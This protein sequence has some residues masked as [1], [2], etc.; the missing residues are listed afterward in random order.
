MVMYA[1]NWNASA[2]IFGTSS[3]F[4]FSNEFVSSTTDRKQ[5]SPHRNELQPSYNLVDGTEPIPCAVN[6]ERRGLEARKVSCPQFIRSFR[7]VE[8]V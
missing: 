6:E 7:R 8:R 5:F 1:N 4:R 2:T 3:R